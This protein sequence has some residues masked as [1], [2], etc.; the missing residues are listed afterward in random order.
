MDHE[1][2]EADVTP[3]RV[4]STYGM[5][6]GGGLAGETDDGNGDR[7]PMPYAYAVVYDWLADNE[8]HGWL[9]DPPKLAIDGDM[10]TVDVYQRTTAGA[11]AP[12]DCDEI[13]RTNEPDGTRTEVRGTVSVP[14]RCALTDQVRAAATLTGLAVEERDQA[15]AGSAC[16]AHIEVF[17]GRTADEP[18]DRH[19]KRFVITSAEWQEAVRAGAEATLLAERQGEALGY[20]GLLMLQT[21]F[22]LGWV[23][24]QWIWH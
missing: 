12:W 13:V 6:V 20:A 5:D 23:Q 1:V 16:R 21:P 24:V 18:V 14:L 22:V 17:A 2:A 10:L 8:V 19:T 11:A 9:P 7:P 4:P 15:T 3:L